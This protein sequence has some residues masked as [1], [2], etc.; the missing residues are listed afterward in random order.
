MD[1][2]NKITLKDVGILVK[3]NNEKLIAKLLSTNKEILDKF[4]EDV[5]GNLLFDGNPINAEVLI[6]TTSD[7]D[8]I[9][10]NE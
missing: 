6:I 8:N 10:G 2:N 5:D 9:I 3:Q 7:I 1:N 4:S